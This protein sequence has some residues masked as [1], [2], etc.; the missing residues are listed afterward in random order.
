VS[1]VD[2]DELARLRRERKAAV[3]ALRDVDL[4]IHMTKLTPG[5]R[6]EPQV[7]TAERLDKIHDAEARVAELD[8][9][10]AALEVR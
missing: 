5:V 9:A 7:L 1:K 4:P 2:N 3:A 8:R 10:I 6:P